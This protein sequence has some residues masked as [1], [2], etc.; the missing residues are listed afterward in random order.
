MAREFAAL[1]QIKVAFTPAPM[2]DEQATRQCDHWRG[3]QAAGG[4]GE[5]AM[6]AVLEAAR[7]PQINKL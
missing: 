1:S 7:K 4:T 6:P 3:A 5:K 2:N